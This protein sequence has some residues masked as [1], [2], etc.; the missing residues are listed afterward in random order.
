M[1]PHLLVAGLCAWAAGAVIGL[2]FDAGRSPTREVPYVAGMVGGALVC[3][4]GVLSVLHRPTTLDLGST[5]GVGR[6]LVRLDGL[7][8]LFLT[9][10][11]ALAVLVSACLVS[12]AHQ[13]GRLTG[14]GTA[15]GYLVMLGSVTV[16]VVAGDAFTFLFAWE[17]LTVAFYIL[18]GVRR[19]RGA[20]PGAAW[21]TFGIGKAS[22]A[23]LLVG[24][25]LLAGR[26]GS[27]TL[28]AWAHVSPG[29]LHDA[30]Y[31][32]VIAG[33]GAKVGLVPFHVWLPVGYP[34][35]PGP[36]RAALAGLAA[37]VGFYGLWR[38]L[39]ILGR[40]PVWLAVV[41][42]VAGGVTALLGIVFAGVE[43]HLDRVVAYSSVENAGL[44]TVGY[45][46]ALA[47]AA[48]SHPRLVAVGLLAASLQVLAH[49]VAKTGLFA[50]GAF[51]TA[52]WGTGTLDD[53]RGVG[54]THRWAG[55]CFGL[56]S[57][58]LAG[59]PPTI[60]F[61]SEWFLLEA[62]M[63]EFRVGPL[64]LRLAMAAAGALVALTAGVA[65]LTF[66]RLLG[67]TILG[68]PF[69][70]APDPTMVTDGGIFGRAGLG[71]LA[72]S[73]VGLA[74]A[75]PWV[76]RFIADGLAPVLPA[77]TVL[78][79]LKSPW[80]LQPVFANFSILSPSWLSVV[81][82]IGFLAVGAFTVALS[83]GRFLRVRRVPAWRSATTGV[84]GADSYSS[85]GYANVARHV[86]GNVLG[87]SRQTVTVEDVADT[88]TL[89]AGHVEA[90]STVV[91]P[92]ET[93]LYRPGRRVL[94]ALANAAKRLQ[95]GR[96]DAYVA[97]MLVALIVVL[98]VVAA[99]P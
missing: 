41:V 61:A 34:A 7:A 18:V 32:L 39:A 45:G 73:C 17:S 94:L 78:G 76:I 22:G 15:A 1:I 10:T 83:R 38:F 60:G 70:P 50:A 69:G 19:D 14:H 54:H 16:I 57:L 71:L 95:S 25:L 98:A 66:V 20:H 46:V 44:I 63:Q 47:G 90:R 56:G 48:T 43:S 77:S 75:S 9:L 31:V 12:W 2:A 33:F 51:I 99:V 89:E 49:A 53:L 28:A 64:E 21:V 80:V 3:A 85:F 88:G 35:A 93:Y 81:M 29:G 86:L 30:A 37:N 8:G 58:T 67:L 52:D 42:L 13:P 36:I 96:L 62:L 26:T 74:A 92:V 68:R 59:L 6:T 97:Y 27:Y 82:P 23:A 40:P 91:E 4:A 84:A 79:A 72:M 55:T 11:A 5:L 24:F 65:A 87:T